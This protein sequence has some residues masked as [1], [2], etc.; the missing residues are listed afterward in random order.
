MRRTVGDHRKITR[1]CEELG[2][3]RKGGFQYVAGLNPTA[4]WHNAA[5]CADFVYVRPLCLYS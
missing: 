4:S 5:M 2:K 3:H 1:T